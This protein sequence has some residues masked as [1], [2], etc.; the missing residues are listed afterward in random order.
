MEEDI[1]GIIT[2]TDTMGIMDIMD[3]T[4]T[5]IIIDRYFDVCDYIGKKYWVEI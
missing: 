1:T 2:I 5:T 3:T 4:D